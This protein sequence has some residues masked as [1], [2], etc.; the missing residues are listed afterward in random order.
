M[1]RKSASS[2][3]RTGQ[4]PSLKRPSGVCAIIPLPQLFAIEYAALFDVINVGLSDLRLPFPLGGSSNHFRTDILRELGGW[5]AW[6]VTEDADLGFRFARFGY[7]SETLAA[8]TLEEAPATLQGFI[9]QRRRWCKGWYQTLCTL[10]R[11]PLRLPREAGL[12]R[13]AAMLL[14]LLSSVLVPLGAP[15]CALCLGFVIARGG[16]SWPSTNLE[17]GAATLW[18]SVLFGG[19]GAV[20]GPILIGMKRRGLR[21]LWP[22]LLLLPA[23]YTLISFAAW[24]GLY[25]LAMRPYHWCKTEHGVGPG[26]RDRNGR[27]DGPGR[28]S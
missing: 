9:G 13:S 5:D 17:I 12:A 19:A 15:L 21:P 14:I 24:M 16:P 1:R 25:D 11:D 20:L 22:K 2:I 10:C 27:I 4:P 23:Y 7:H 26:R 18:T 8:T 6:N 28:V 3:A